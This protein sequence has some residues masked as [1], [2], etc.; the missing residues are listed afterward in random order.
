MG[1]EGGDINR[2]GAEWVQTVRVRLETTE[3]D[4]EA[5]GIGMETLVCSGCVGELRSPTP[6]RRRLMVL[7]GPGCSHQTQGVWR[8]FFGLEVLEA[9]IKIMGIGVQVRG[10]SE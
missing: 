3:E 1:G 10:D 6:F 2:G 9:S 8:L 7:R 5:L 4:V